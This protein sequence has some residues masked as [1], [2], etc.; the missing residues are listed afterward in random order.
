MVSV[1]ADAADRKLLAPLASKDWSPDALAI[2]PR[3]VYQWCST[4]I[5][6]SPVAEAVTR[7]LRDR[8]TARNWTTIQK[9]HALATART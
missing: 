1:L 9:L 8:T 6:K 2:G 7:A 3:A 4:G 5:L